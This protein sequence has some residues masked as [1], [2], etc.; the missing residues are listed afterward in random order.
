MQKLFKIVKD[1]AKSIRERCTPVET[2]FSQEIIDLVNDMHDYLVLSQDEEYAKKHKLR[3]G[4]GLAA[5]Q[6][7]RNIR[8]LCV[9]YEDKDEKGNI[10]KV[11]DHR[12]INPKII[13]ESV[14]LCTLDGEGCLSVDEV[15]EGYVYRPYRIIVDAYDV[16]EGKQVKIQASGYEA[17]VLQHEIDHLNGVLFYDHIN[18]QNP[19]YEVPGS[20]KI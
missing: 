11:I 16:K 10:T 20:I 14:K 19:F 2:P 17:I 3:E 1:N 12:L 8:A 5:P 6:I 9:Y 15:H 4:V 13:S 7:G 18:K